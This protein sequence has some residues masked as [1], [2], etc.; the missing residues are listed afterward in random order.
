M[1]SAFA[2]LF[3]LLLLSLSLFIQ[4]CG[5]GSNDE[6]LEK[7]YG[8]N[9]TS[10]CEET[11][12][13]F[14]LALSIHLTKNETDAEDLYAK[15]MNATIAYYQQKL[16]VSTNSDRAKLYDKLFELQT[17][18]ERESR[19]QKG[20]VNLKEC[21]H[22]A[23]LSEIVIESE[24]NSSGY[25]QSTQSPEVFRYF[26]H[27]FAKN[28]DYFSG[29]LFPAS[30]DERRI[31]NYGVVLDLTRLQIYSEIVESIEV[32]ETNDANNSIKA[33]DQ[34]LEVGEPSD[35]SSLAATTLKS[36]KSILTNENAFNLEKRFIASDKKYLAVKVK[37]A[38]SGKEETLVLEK[39]EKQ[40]LPTVLVETPSD[41]L[42]YA[43]VTE[44]G[45]GTAA[46]LHSKMAAAKL[47][48]LEKHLDKRI[49]KIVDLS[50]TNADPS[51]IDAAKAEKPQIGIILDLRFN[52]G[53]AVSELKNMAQDFIGSGEVGTF[54]RR[55]GG[56]AS[57]LERKSFVLESL[58]KSPEE[59]FSK[60]PMIV[61]VNSGSASSSDIITQI[62][63]ETGRAY[64][65]GENSFGKAIGQSYIQ[66]GVT[67]YL[68]GTL[69]IT[70]LRFYGPSGKNIQ[71]LGVT[72]DEVVV[73]SRIEQLKREC[74]GVR[75]CSAIRMADI[76][77]R[78][79]GVTIPTADAIHPTI[80]MAKAAKTTIRSKEM[81]PSTTAPAVA[82]TLISSSSTPAWIE[83]DTILKRAIEVLERAEVK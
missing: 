26:L 55:G 29:Y 82:P 12:Q 24:R 57:G 28:L 56:S 43:R 62:L 68:R 23:Q 3:S 16:S 47:A 11:N 5:G 64:V 66:L 80:N 54:E 21:T 48:L 49:D 58:A 69:K 22:L 31:G 45:E 81:R 76:N 73:D 71:M 14:N 75:K 74:G 36:V 51:E 37:K 18:V 19:S 40:K 15:A 20:T 83:N 39:T 72:P 44:F 6:P 4:A 79:L 53:G 50:R 61:L 34:I 63:Q 52:P 70:S 35:S 77:S 46:E 27:F 2:L 1:K 60:E 33:H 30:S 65:I 42:I 32:L 41:N 8:V 9:G 13:V 10:Y 17:D 67:S 59:D 78:R 7:I 25:S 38:S